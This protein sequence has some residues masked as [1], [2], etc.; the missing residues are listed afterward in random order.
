MTDAH[1]QLAFNLAGEGL[2]DRTFAERAADW[3]AEHPIGFG[4]FETFAL[5]AARQQR[6]F[7]WKQIAER[8]RWECVIEQDGDWKVNNNLVT[9]IGELVAEKHAWIRPWFETR[10]REHG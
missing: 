2:D 4:L 7:G 5:R 6:R 1:T 3:A 10:R 9:Y 8:V